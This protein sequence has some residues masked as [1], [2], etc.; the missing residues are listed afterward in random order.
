MTMSD[1]RRLPHTTTLEVLDTLHRLAAVPD[2][3]VAP[4][5]EIAGVLV[6][7][8]GQGKAAA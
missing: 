6:E 3:R 5:E 2:A 7:L 4:L 8:C 1:G